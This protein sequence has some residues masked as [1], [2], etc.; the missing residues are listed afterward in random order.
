MSD[1][2]IRLF[3]LEGIRGYTPL[4]KLE[5]AELIIYA[6][7]DGIPGHPLELDRV[8]LQRTNAIFH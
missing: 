5:K 7:I 3:D 8:V 6:R 1:H 2:R 4:K